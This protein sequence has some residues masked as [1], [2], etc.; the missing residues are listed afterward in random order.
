M[1]AE[2]RVARPQGLSRC[3]HQSS[4]ITWYPL[5]ANRKKDISLFNRQTCFLELSFLWEVKEV[6][7]QTL[8]SLSRAQGAVMG[9]LHGGKLDL[10]R[11]LRLQLSN[12]GGPKV[13]LQ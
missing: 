10:I 7:Q 1:Q 8:K 4:E 12:S 3:H 9:Q 5:Q 11:G 13:A 2:L 6:L